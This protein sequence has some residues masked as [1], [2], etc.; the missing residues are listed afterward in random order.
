MREAAR[1]NYIF[2]LSLGLEQQKMMRIIKGIVVRGRRIGHEL[3]F[4]T[5]NIEADGIDDVADGIYAVRVMVGGCEYEGM[6][7]LG[8]RPSISPTDAA[9]L[10][11]VNI[12]GFDGD[13]YGQPI[14]VSLIR[15]IRPE[16]RF[17]NLDQLRN[18]ILQDRNTIEQFFKHLEK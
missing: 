15:F 1:A 13:L 16:K 14:E 17:D 8:Y 12:F 18:A 7:N 5:A 6:A 2:L 4:P 3:G 9:R 11:E 10:L